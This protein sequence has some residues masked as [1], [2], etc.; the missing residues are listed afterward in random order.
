[1]SANERARGE[2]LKLPRAYTSSSRKEDIERMQEDLRLLK[3]R[4][5]Q[6]S[7]SESE[8]EEERRK[9]RRGPSALEQELS[10]YKHAR[11]RAAREK[12][13]PKDRRN[14][15]DDLLRDLGM[16][17]KKVMEADV[18]EEE[19]EENGEVAGDE[20]LE[21][22]DDVGWLKHSLKFAEEISDET[23]RAEDEYTVSFGRSCRA[24][25]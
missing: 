19:V 14:N 2:W 7:D 15:D 18:E 10:K 24:S 12:Y 5:G 22:D 1:M 17:T 20:G 16:F 21:V 25:M 4:T 3:K 6:D 13:N 8:D 9:R 11:G 23:R